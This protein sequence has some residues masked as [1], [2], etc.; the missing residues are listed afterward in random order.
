MRIYSSHEI[1]N[2]N[3]LKEFIEKVKAVDPNATGN[4]IQTYEA[5]IQMMWSYERSGILAFIAIFV[6]ILFDFRSLVQTLQV[7]IPF[8]IGGLMGF[9]LMGLLNIPFNPANTIV[10]P[11]ILG[12]GVDDGVHLVH[13]YREQKKGEYRI[14]PSLVSSIIITTLTSIIGFGSLMIADHRG[15]QSLG[16]VLVIGLSS[17]TF[18]SLVVMPAVFTIRNNL[19]RKKQENVEKIIDR[20]DKKS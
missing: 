4:P 1:W 2:M 9:G 18:V 19:Y 14:P 12:I 17:C 7:M 16:R 15:L 6:L 8:G 3:E 10:A 5:S 20:C 11:L 13:N